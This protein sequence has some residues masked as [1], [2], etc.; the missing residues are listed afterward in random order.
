[1]SLKEGEYSTSKTIKLGE[2]NNNFDECL[3]LADK[4]GIPMFTYWT[5]GQ[6]CSWCV[7]FE[8]ECFRTDT[9]KEW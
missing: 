3:E 7:K 2:W 1:M 5:P 8:D 4:E 9:F 6:G